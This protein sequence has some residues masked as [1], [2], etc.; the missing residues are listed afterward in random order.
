MAVEGDAVM[1][2]TQS[3][4]SLCSLICLGNISLVPTVLRLRVPLKAMM[5][6]DSHPA[7]I[8]WTGSQ[9][10]GNWQRNKHEMDIRQGR[11][12]EAGFSAP[13]WDSFPKRKK[14]YHVK[15]CGHSIDKALH[16]RGGLN[17][18]KKQQEGINSSTC[19]ILFHWISFPALWSR[20]YYHYLPNQ[21]T[22]S[23]RVDIVR[24]ALPSYS[25]MK[26]GSELQSDLEP[27]AF[28]VSPRIPSTKSMVKD[29]ILALP[30]GNCSGHGSD[31][32]DSVCRLSE[33]NYLCLLLFRVL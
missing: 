16:M 8:T 6:T 14:P 17:R 29:C 5:R 27:E 26:A 22:K 12:Q 15:L 3:L 20:W 1:S 21:G 24:L 10:S 19:H 32:F 30:C 2:W 31:W 9:V 13:Q 23:Q 11:L 4:P 18:A 33:A 7:A 28:P 25:G